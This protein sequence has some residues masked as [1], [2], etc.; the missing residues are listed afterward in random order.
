MSNTETLTIEVVETCVYRA[1]IALT[2]ELLDEA[3]AGGY[4]RT[5]DGVL[6]MLRADP[7]HE[8]VTSDAT[9]ERYFD[10]VAERTVERA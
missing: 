7:D 5:A 4:A 9:E 1:P 6:K 3:E 10:H 2:T 8:V